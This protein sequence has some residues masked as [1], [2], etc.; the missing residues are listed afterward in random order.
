MSSY[1]SYLSSWPCWR[2]ITVIYSHLDRDCLPNGGEDA[3]RPFG[4]VSA[5]R[6]KSVSSTRY[7]ES[8]KDKQ[9]ES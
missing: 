9:G 6:P 5:M 4:F 3:E 7:S 1:Y 8:A 2:I